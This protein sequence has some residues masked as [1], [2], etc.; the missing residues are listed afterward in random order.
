MK[1]P[2]ERC[3]FCGIGKQPTPFGLYHYLY[4]YPQYRAAR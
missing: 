1:T 3:Q 4:C 2:A